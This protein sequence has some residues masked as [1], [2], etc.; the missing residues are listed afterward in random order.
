[1]NGTGRGRETECV[2]ASLLPGRPY[3]FQ[4]RAYNR[5]GVGPWSPPLEVISGQLPFLKYRT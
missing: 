2:V 1:M 4:V 3:L 5:A